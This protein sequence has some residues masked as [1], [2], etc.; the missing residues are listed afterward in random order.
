MLTFGSKLLLYFR[1]KIL[2]VAF[3]LRRQHTDYSGMDIFMT[4]CFQKPKLCFL[5][6]VVLQVDKLNLKRSLI[7]GKCIFLTRIYNALQKM[8]FSL[9]VLCFCSCP[10][11]RL[12]EIFHHWELKGRGLIFS[13][14]DWGRKRTEPHCGSGVTHSMFETYTRQTMVL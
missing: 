8:Y 12:E 7:L 11:P 5:W 14:C 1:K 9:R 6:K 10:S 13:R 4:L 2:A 3:G